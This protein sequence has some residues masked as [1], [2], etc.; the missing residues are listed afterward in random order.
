[1]GQLHL[2]AKLQE[3]FGHLVHGMQSYHTP[4]TPGQWI[5]RVKEDWMKISKEDQKLYHLAVETQIYLL[6]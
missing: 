4:G 2:I 1:V 5:V 3:K 6:K